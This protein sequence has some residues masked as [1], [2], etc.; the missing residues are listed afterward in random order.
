[1][2]AIKY[3]KSQLEGMWH[4]QKATLESVTD[5]IVMKVPEGTVSPI[6]VIWLH[7]VS[8][9]DHFTAIIT[10]VQSL[11]KTEGWDEKFSVEKAPGFG[12]DWST[13]Q[14]MEW[15]IELLQD[16]TLAVKAFVQQA[17]DSMDNE[18]LDERVKFFTDSDPKSDVWVL[19]IGHTLHHC[20]EIAAINGVFGGKGLPF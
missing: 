9:Q 4:L 14:G 16:Y 13:Y 2:E 5:D 12:M 15:S 3:L 1:M 6:G 19:L 10:G 8:T 20:G 7:L 18:T 11:W 17:V